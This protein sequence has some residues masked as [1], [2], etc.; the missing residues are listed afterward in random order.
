MKQKYLMMA[1]AAIGVMA[2]KG[3]EYGC[4]GESGWL[5]ANSVPHPIPHMK[6]RGHGRKPNRSRKHRTRS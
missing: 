3:L 4:G 1:V 2:V 5:L 6:S